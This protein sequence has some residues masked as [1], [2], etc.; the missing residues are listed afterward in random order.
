MDPSTCLLDW[1][2]SA[3]A[4]GFDPARLFGPDPRSAPCGTVRPPRQKPFE[5]PSGTAQ[6][7]RVTEPTSAGPHEAPA[8]AA[9]IDGVEQQLGLLFARIR[10]NTAAAARLIHPEL[11][12]GAYPI[13]LRI[14]EAAPVRITDLAA[15]FGVGK[16]TMSRQVANLERIGLVQRAADPADR[17]GALVSLSEQGQ[18]EFARVRAVRHEWLQKVLGGFSDD[19][20]TEFDRLL[21]TFLR[22]L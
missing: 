7:A 9:G 8:R 20:L 2:G 17:R 14:N 13:L 16:P 3:D 18:Q 19:E 15:H 11:G 12:T 4:T 6:E 5:Q 22:A 21:G 1:V 10:A